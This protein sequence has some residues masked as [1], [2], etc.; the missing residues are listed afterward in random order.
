MPKSVTACMGLSCLFHTKLLSHGVETCIIKA[1]DVEFQH[2][3]LH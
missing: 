3:K 1:H 2:K